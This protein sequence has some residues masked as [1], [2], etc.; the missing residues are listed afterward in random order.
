VR[1]PVIERDDVLAAERGGIVP[2]VVAG[3]A[4]ALR[5]RH[6][7]ADGVAGGVGGLPAA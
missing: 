1:E 2:A 3:Q 4:Q 5:Q 7:S 6:G